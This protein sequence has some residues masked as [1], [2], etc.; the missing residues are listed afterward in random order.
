MLWEFGNLWK[1]NDHV[2][3]RNESATL[4]LQRHTYG[5]SSTELD[6]MQWNGQWKGQCMQECAKR[7]L[8][9]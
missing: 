4:R 8:S 3:I 1:F 6:G 7:N 2:V 9:S 5:S